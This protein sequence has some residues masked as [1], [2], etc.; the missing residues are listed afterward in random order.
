MGTF[1]RTVRQVPEPWDMQ[2][3]I[4]AHDAD[5]IRVRARRFG[6]GPQV[7]LSV[8]TGPLL[9]HCLDGAAVGSVA[10]AWAAAQ[11]SSAHLLPMRAARPAQ[12]RQFTPTAWPNADVVAEGP[13]RW[14]VAAPEAGRPFVTVTTHWLTVRVHDLPALQ[15]YTH[16]WAQACAVGLQVMVHPAPSFE[17]LL[18]DAYDREAVRRYERD[19]PAA[20]RGRSRG[21]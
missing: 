17:Q 2:V 10:A 8:R 7:H 13:Q 9:V 5:L 4:D 6:D 11:A 15:T 18:R 12:R 19:H 20:R 3:A 14:T 1:A 21:R 16:A